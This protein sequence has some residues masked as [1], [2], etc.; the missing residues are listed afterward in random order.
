MR[1]MIQEHPQPPKKL[2]LHIIVCLLSNYSI[3]YCGRP[4][5]VTTK[6]GAGGFSDKYSCVQMYIDGRTGVRNQGVQLHAR[7][8]DPVDWRNVL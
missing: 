5:G 4:K 8:I 7:D 1:M 6:I 2:L 3:V